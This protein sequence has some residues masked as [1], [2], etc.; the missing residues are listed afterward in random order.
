MISAFSLRIQI[1]QWIPVCSDGFVTGHDG[2]LF[3]SFFCL[4]VVATSMDVP[5]DIL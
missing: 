5:S 2:L 1:F 4:G 3:N